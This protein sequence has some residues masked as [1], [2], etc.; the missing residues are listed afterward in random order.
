MTK[1][2]STHSGYVLLAFPLQKWL[3]ERAPMLCY[4][5][6][7]CLVLSNIALH[8]EKFAIRGTQWFKVVRWLLVSAWYKSYYTFTESAESVACVNLRWLTCCIKYKENSYRTFLVVWDFGF[9]RILTLINKF[10]LAI[11]IYTFSLRWHCT[12]GCIEVN[13]TTICD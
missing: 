4:T 6:I 1:A 13:A 2:T 10:L 11:I 7:G 5:Y 3:H 12:S 8:G 9:R